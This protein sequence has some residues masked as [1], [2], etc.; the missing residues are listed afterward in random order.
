MNQRT[1]KR[2]RKRIY[3][4]HG[5]IHEREYVTDE[6]TK[7]VINI[8]MRRMCQDAKQLYKERRSRG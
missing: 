3:G 7:V 5:S 4:S 2:I 8:G 1:A 6:K